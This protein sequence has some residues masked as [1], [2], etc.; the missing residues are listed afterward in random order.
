MGRE[1]KEVEE[2]LFLPPHPCCI[3]GEHP[4][5][6]QGCDTRAEGKKVSELLSE[7]VCVCVCVCLSVC[8]CVCVCGQ[9]QG[10]KEGLINLERV[11]F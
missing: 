9:G 5:N 3:L 8:V 6:R 10:Q 2:E 4:P 7:R 11:G 1:Q